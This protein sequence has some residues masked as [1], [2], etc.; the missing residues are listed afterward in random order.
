MQNVV[1]YPRPNSPGIIEWVLILGLGID[2]VN[3][4]DFQALA[5]VRID[6]AK[7]L[8]DQ[9]MFDGAYYLAGYAV[10]C[11][12]KSCI[13]RLTIEH[14]FPPR[15]TG[16]YYSHQVGKLVRTAGLTVQ[17]NTDTG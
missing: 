3:R 14:D 16:D 2:A 12:L 8:L 9:G 7:V 13:A 10:E 1:R 15:N 4:T 11:A 5:D 17:L 6:E